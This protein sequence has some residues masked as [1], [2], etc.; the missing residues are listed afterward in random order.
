MRAQSDVQTLALSF[1]IPFIRLYF[2]TTP[3]YQGSRPHRKGVVHF[4]TPPD[5]IK[6]TFSETLFIST[7]SI[8]SLL[9]A[10]Y[11]P[12]T[13]LLVTLEFAIPATPICLKYYEAPI[14][15]ESISRYALAPWGM[16][17]N[18]SPRRVC[19]PHSARFAARPTASGDMRFPWAFHCSCMSTAYYTTLPFYTLLP[20]SFIGNNKNNL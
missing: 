13:T 2:D 9:H 6:I 3:E 11:L 7:S 20:V 18:T 12:T 1:P 4:P 14:V 10:N 17:P 19:T 15:K 16:Q 8:V 5:I